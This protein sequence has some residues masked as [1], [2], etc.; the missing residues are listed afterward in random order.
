MFEREAVIID[1]R[2]VVPGVFLLTLRD[3]FIA[4]EAEPGQFVM[5]RV[6]AGLDPLLRRPFSI[7]AL[8]GEDAFR[9]L[10]RVVGRGTALLSEAVEGD[11]LAVLGPLGSGFRIDA[12]S[13]PALL[14][15]GGMGVAPLFFL[16][17]ALFRTETPPFTFLAGFPSAGEVVGPAEILGSNLKLELA[18]EDGSA[19]Y[20]GFVTELLR[21]RLDSDGPGAFG[22]VY[23]C[24]PGAMLARI[25]ALTSERSI[26]CQVSLEAAMACGLGACLGCAVHAAPGETA[27]YYRVCREGPVFDARIL[28]WTR[29]EHPGTGPNEGEAV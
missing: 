10:Y 20:A 17:Q 11:A 9:L 23:A 7:C 12:A 24:G 25:A 18:T 21:D 3:P 16:A 4:K 15:G 19:G 28:D 29:T 1:H 5:V 14:V 2:E 26:S 13:G 6:H 27:S 8:A 22:S